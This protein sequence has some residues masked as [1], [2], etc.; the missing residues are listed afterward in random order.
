MKRHFKEIF[1]ISIA[2]LVLII[3]FTRPLA[4]KISTDLPF[5]QLTSD[6]SVFVWNAWWM[7]HAL[8]EGI[9]P[10]TTPLLFY[11]LH[12][13]LTLHSMNWLNSTLVALLAKHDNIIPAFN[14]IF[15]LSI[16]MSA[17]GMYLLV[18][19][20]GRSVIA[21]FSSGTAFAFTPY[22]LAHSLGHFNLTNIFVLPWFLLFFIAMAGWGPSLL[23]KVPHTYWSCSCSTGCI[24][25]G[26]LIISFSA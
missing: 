25:F 20:L 22:L 10:F 12:T 13:N 2:F 18:R 21:A 5:P 3:I 23:E 19:Q 11:P 15:L 26:F 24:L 8:S 16:F 14:L 4:M 9:S 17:M 1:L 7:H 6:G